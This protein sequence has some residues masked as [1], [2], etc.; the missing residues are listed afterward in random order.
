MVREDPTPT[1]EA[2]GKRLIAYVIPYAE[3]P[4]ANELHAF[5]KTK[6][7]A[8]MIPAGFVVLDEF[9]LNSSGKVNRRAL[10]VPQLDNLAE[11]GEFVE[12]DTP[13]ERLLAQ[14]S[15][16]VLG[17]EQI[18]RNDNFF[19]LGGHSLMA[20]QLVSRVRDTFEIDLP[21]QSMFEVPTVAGLA[22]QIETLQWASEHITLPDGQIPEHYE[23]D[24]I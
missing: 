12:P 14:I 3:A 9:P 19:E 2:T 16:Q 23:E 15:K 1:G 21:L 8:H 5:L 18:G 13:V 4:T 11:Q 20:T 17:I 10:P 22:E 6:L 7:P 24:E